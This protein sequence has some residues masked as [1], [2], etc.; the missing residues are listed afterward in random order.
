MNLERI[1]V[2]F[3][4]LVLQHARQKNRSSVRGVLVGQVGNSLVKVCSLLEVCCVYPSKDDS[5]KTTR[6]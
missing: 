1:I 6:P 3:R 2:E 4:F 5:D